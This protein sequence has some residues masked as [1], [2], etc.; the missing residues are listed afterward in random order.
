[1]ISAIRK[2]PS[3][4]VQFD[5]EPMAAAS[6]DTMTGDV[7]IE[8]LTVSHEGNHGYRL[9]IETGINYWLTQLQSVETAEERAFASYRLGCEYGTLGNF[10][11]AAQYF[12]DSLKDDNSI[13]NESRVQAALYYFHA[14]M[15]Q[16]G[17]I[18]SVTLSE[19]EQYAIDTPSDDH[20]KN[21]VQILEF[22]IA[23]YDKGDILPDTRDRAAEINLYLAK[24]EGKNDPYVRRHYLERAE[25]AHPTAP[26]I[27]DE[28]RIGLLDIGKEELP[29]LSNFSS[30]PTEEN[31]IEEDVVVCREGKKVSEVVSEE[32]AYESTR[33]LAQRL[34]N[35]GLIDEEDIDTA[36][37]HFRASPIP[38]A[39]NGLGRIGLLALNQYLR[40]GGTVPVHINGIR[41]EPLEILAKRLANEGDSTYGDIFQRMEIRYGHALRVNGITYRQDWLSIGGQIIIVDNEREDLPWDKLPDG[42]RER[43]CVIDATGDKKLYTAEGSTEKHIGKGVA[44]VLFTAP[45]EDSETP[46]MVLGAIENEFL[47]LVDTSVLSNASCTTNSLAP[48]T[49]ILKEAYGVTRGSMFTVHAYT[50]QAIIPTLTDAKSLGRAESALREIGYTSTGAAKLIPVLV[51]LLS[52]GKESPLG[53]HDGFALRVPTSTVS[54]IGYM[55]ELEKL[56]SKQDIIRAFKAKEAEDPRVMKVVPD[57][58]GLAVKGSDITSYVDPKKIRVLMKTAMS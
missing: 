20:N 15:I 36:V 11:D 17:G 47:Q 8:Q 22:I 14:V 30:L 56:A 52:R 45:P 41:E 34:V 26:D 13:E 51:R 58:N 32:E 55:V 46:I 50:S 5:G 10:E 49:A 6:L 38:I 19:L 42:I 48:S 18:E 37:E 28:I 3:A 2:V 9:T 23:N 35:S 4:W 54:G 53:P 29:R 57:V 7:T 40:R 39:I 12:I 33:M 21:A 31:L 44:S 1:S 24:T 16:E 25:A 27:Q 43:T